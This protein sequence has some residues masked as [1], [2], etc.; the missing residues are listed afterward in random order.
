MMSELAQ[1]ACFSQYGESID[2][3]DTERLLERFMVWLTTEQGLSLGFDSVALA[4]EAPDLRQHHAEHGDGPTVDGN[5][6]GD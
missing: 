3:S 4:D 6:Q 2:R 5:R 1:I